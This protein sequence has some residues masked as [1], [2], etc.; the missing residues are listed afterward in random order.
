MCVLRVAH[1]C[2]Q[3]TRAQLLHNQKVELPLSMR[4]RMAKDA[5]LG[6]VCTIAPLPTL[7]VVASPSPIEHQY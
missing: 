7:A 2:L 4:M 6:M 3:P 5:A 1:C